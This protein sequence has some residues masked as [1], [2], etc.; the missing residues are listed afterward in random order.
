MVLLLLLLGLL[1]P[2]QDRDLNPGGDRNLGAA[3]N[4]QDHEIGIG[5][6]DQDLGSGE[7]VPDLE[8]SDSFLYICLVMKL[9]DYSDL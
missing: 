7:D 8:V 3:V 5:G 9:L 6:G 2:D 4:A 1:T